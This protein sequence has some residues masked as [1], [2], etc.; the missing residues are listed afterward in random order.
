MNLK[1]TGR[2]QSTKT[3]KLESPRE[4]ER[5]KLRRAAQSTVSRCETS[6]LL[7]PAGQVE[8]CL[9]LEKC[10][11]HLKKVRHASKEEGMT[12]KDTQTRGMRKWV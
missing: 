8:V 4:V 2:E 5:D 12:G 6:P 10:E 9:L 7:R 1:R 3:G 11:P